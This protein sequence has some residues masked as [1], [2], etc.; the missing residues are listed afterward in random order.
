LLAGY[1]YTI[2][3][4]HWNYKDELKF[5]NLVVENSTQIGLSYLTLAKFI[6]NRES[7]NN[8]TS[9][10]FKSFELEPQHVFSLESEEI[11]DLLENA[12]TK[13]VLLNHIFLG[14]S[15]NWSQHTLKEEKKED[16]EYW[17][18]RFEKDPMALSIFDQY[19]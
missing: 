6:R 11:E 9:V 2:Y 1:N 17:Y 4:C 8:W 18:H 3:T 19:I 10:L 16:L 12:L 5:W 14:H 15:S 7:F 13:Y